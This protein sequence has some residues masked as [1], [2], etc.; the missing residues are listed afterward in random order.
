MIDAPMPPPP[1]DVLAAALAFF[2]EGKIESAVEMCQQA[3]A[4]DPTSAS[5]HDAL[6]QIF[7]KNKEYARAEPSF[8]EA[9]RLDSDQ[10][11]YALHLAKGLTAQERYY[12]ALEV[13]EVFARS[14]PR[15]V[16]AHIHLGLAAA[17]CFEVERAERALQ[18]AIALNPK[19]PWGY[20]HLGK[21]M[22]SMGQT[23]KACDAFSKVAKIESKNLLQFGKNY[24]EVLRTLNRVEES[25]AVCG[26][27]VALANRSVEALHFLADHFEN[28]G[29]RD[30]SIA[31]LRECLEID[32][33]DHIALTAMGNR[34]AGLGQFEE[35]RICLMKALALAGQSQD[36]TRKRLA[37]M[38]C[39][40]FN[41]AVMNQ[42]PK[43]RHLSRE[44]PGPPRLIGNEAI[45]IRGGMDPSYV[46]VV[47][48]YRAAHPN[49][50]II[51][52]TWNDT[53]EQLIGAVAEHVDDLVLNVRPPLPGKSNLNYQIVCAGN[54]V[55]RAKELGAK[56]ILLTRTDVALLRPHLLNDLR[57][58]YSDHPKSNLPS[59]NTK[60]RLIVS[61]LFSFY[62]PFYH[63]SD[64]FMYGHADDVALYWSLDHMTDA[65]LGTESTLARSFAN[66]I[67]W[68]IKNTTSDSISLY[69]ECFIVRPSTWFDFFWIKN[70]C[71]ASTADVPTGMDVMTEAM[72]TSSQAD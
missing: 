63:V 22:M 2:D 5:Y 26:H 20:M 71:R 64:I 11:S 57:A 53:P 39:R 43:V 40:S 59:L 58:L 25:L 27:V 28:L 52:S 61:D 46:D 60:G 50:F 38:Y 4:Q 3:V 19:D 69:Q 32:S 13:F 44:S 9:V 45:V 36:P 55:I 54:G 33:N 68:L 14:H 37:E 35:A 34:L 7:L 41:H 12:E 24:S 70:P 48:H 65:C 16:V 56:R 15:M 66:K 42:L 72:W 49:T 29:M 67:G 10:L 21:A 8:R 18:T 51:L 30:R 47:R 1:C 17:K 6:G 62:R 31:T 23:Q